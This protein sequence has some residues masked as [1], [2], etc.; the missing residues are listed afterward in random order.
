MERLQEIA[1]KGFSPSALTN[2]IRNPIE[3]YRKKVLRINEF[4]ELEE[5]VAYNTL[6][7]IVHDSL[8]E[9]YEPWE[10]SFLNLEMLQK[11]KT[12]IEAVV[13]RQFKKSF[14]EGN[15]S[16]GKNLIIFEV[17]KRYI[18]NFINLEIS[19]ISEGKTINI[20]QI[21]TDLRIEIPM[22]RLSFPVFIGGKVDRVDEY[23]GVLRIVDYKTGMVKQ[24]ELEII[25][26][27]LINEDYK[28]SKAFQ[29]LAYALMMNSSTPIIYAEA[30][31]ISFKN[32]S[33]GFLKFGTKEKSRSQNKNQLL[34]QETLDAFS[35]EL[36]KLLLEICDPSIPFIE[37]EI[38]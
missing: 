27:N 19:E 38:E 2:Y 21:E 4:Q 10:G 35:I 5:T 23:N 12:Q 6:G 25:D 24:G 22:E 1:Q 26:W 13:T 34:T 3:F 31:I 30:G 29:V 14:K 28:Y 32:L 36:K 7:T 33:N 37:K 11:A 20:L 16:K 18:L 8:Q 9:I 17:A 15:Y